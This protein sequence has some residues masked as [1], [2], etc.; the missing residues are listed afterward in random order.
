M[1]IKNRL[2][3]LEQQQRGNSGAW[4]RI[5]VNPG[6]TEQTAIERWQSENPNITLPGNLVFRVIVIY[7]KAH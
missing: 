1:T 3:K 4:E 2:A 7:L 6:E 5:I